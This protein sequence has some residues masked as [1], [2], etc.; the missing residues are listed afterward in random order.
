MIF[1]SLQYLIFLPIAVFLYW[2]T[3]GG[4]RL[5]VVVA[6]SYFF[7]MSWLPVYGLLLFFLTCANWLLGLAIE[8]SRNRWRKAWLGAAL[9]LNLGCL[10]YYKYTNFLLE[11]L[12]AAFN[13]VRAAVPWLA[14]G[15]PAW[16]AP[17][18]NILLPLGI[19]FFVFEFVHYT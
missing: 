5:A 18:L 12:A 4:A 9:L 13:S 15:V 11:N 8:R 7:Y 19:S 6:A 3:R 2:R 10:F 1:S 17:V 14:G 16:D